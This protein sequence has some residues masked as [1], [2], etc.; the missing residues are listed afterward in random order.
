MESYVTDTNLVYFFLMSYLVYFNNKIYN[1][2]NG[3]ECGEQVGHR[4]MHGSTWS[5]SDETPLEH[6]R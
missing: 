1:F 3:P 2:S 4:G 5:M 6:S